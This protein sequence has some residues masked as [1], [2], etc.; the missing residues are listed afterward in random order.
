MNT[1]SAN[2]LV[3][4]DKIYWEGVLG[5]QR[6]VSPWKSPR[7]G[8]EKAIWMRGY[9]DGLDGLRRKT[10][11][12]MDSAKFEDQRQIDYVA[13]RRQPRRPPDD[14][15]QQTRLPQRFSSER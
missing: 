3:P 7:R 13:P 6:G 9:L 15:G 12:H 14:V 10:V 11:L 5:A 1:T 2:E 4:R 8:V